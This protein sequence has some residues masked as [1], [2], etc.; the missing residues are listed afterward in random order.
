ME[1]DRR[2]LVI[3]KH[4]YWDMPFGTLSNVTHVLNADGRVVVLTAS[5][6]TGPVV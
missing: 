4:T 3:R 6:L 2:L 1:T 5:T